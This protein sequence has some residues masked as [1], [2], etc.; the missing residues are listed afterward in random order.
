MVLGALVLL[1]VEVNASPEVEVPEKDLA[2]ARAQYERRQSAH[3]ARRASRPPVPAVPSRVE[4]PPR[5]ERAKRPSDA[6]RRTSSPRAPRRV[7]TLE[8]APRP[9]REEELQSQRADIRKLYDR[10]RHDEALEV[11]EEYLRSDPEQRYVR[12]VAATSACALGE[13]DAARTHFD[14]LPP[15]DQRIV[16]TRCTRFGLDL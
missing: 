14:E 10:G 5:A 6:A 3:R 2:Q 1:L 16:R 15:T 9:A 8:T 12:R 4:R 11:A 13:V 7:P